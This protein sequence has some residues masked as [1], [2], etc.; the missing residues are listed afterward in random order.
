MEARCGEL[1]RQSVSAMAKLLFPT[2]GISNGG[3]RI[4]RVTCDRIET[5]TSSDHAR[6][7]LDMALWRHHMFGLEKLP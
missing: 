2:F 1:R 6:L 5:T 7:Y 3:W 4:C